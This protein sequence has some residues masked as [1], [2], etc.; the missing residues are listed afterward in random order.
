[1]LYYLGVLLFNSSS[2]LETIV[3]QS[4]GTIYHNTASKV[5]LAIA[6]FSLSSCNSFSGTKYRRNGNTADDKLM[7]IVTM[8]MK[9][10]TMMVIKI[11]NNDRNWDEDAGNDDDVDDVC[12]YLMMMRIDADVDDDDA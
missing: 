12:C 2:A 10:K 6:Y 7:M 9:V 11:K 8:I 3:L 1:M 5:V 4:S